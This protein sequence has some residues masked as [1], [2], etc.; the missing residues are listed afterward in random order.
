[1]SGA[2]LVLC[3]SATDAEAFALAV[4]EGMSVG[5]AWAWKA[6]GTR[7]S[8]PDTPVDAALLKAAAGKRVLIVWRRGEAHLHEESCRAL[9]KALYVQSRA[10]DVA[11]AAFG[12]ED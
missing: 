7:G 6:G 11:A 5:D 12:P 2:R 3:P 1:V 10:V 8:S 4:G 9:A